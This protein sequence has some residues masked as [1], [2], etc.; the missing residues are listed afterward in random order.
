[1]VPWTS[2][3]K[4]TGVLELL[5]LELLLLLLRAEGASSFSS[6]LLF[7]SSYSSFD[8]LAEN[9]SDPSCFLG[10]SSLEQQQHRQ[11]I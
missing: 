8:F 5:L 6:C 11:R 10:Q 2:L 1:M 7:C 4:P 3:L 9:E